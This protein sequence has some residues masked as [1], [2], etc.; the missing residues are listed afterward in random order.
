MVNDFWR[1]IIGSG[2]I[3]MGGGNPMYAQM[4]LQQQR[5]A[6]EK[7][8]A[9]QGLTSAVGQFVPPVNVSPPVQVGGSNAGF[10]YG[11]NATPTIQDI[12]P[13]ILKAAAA[14]VDVTPFVSLLQGM[15]PASPTPQFAPDGR[16]IN[17]SDPKNLGRNFAQPPGPDSLIRGRP[18]DQFFSPTDPTKPVLSIPGA[19]SASPPQ[20]R[21]RVEGDKT[22]VEEFRDGKWAKVSEGPRWAPAKSDDGGPGIT[23]QGVLRREFNTEAG[24]F[25]TVAGSTVRA[26]EAAKD[27]TAA[28]DLALI[29]NYMKI[30]DP[31]SVVRESEFATAQ[32]S[33][34]VPEQIRAQYNRVVNGER[35]SEATRKDFVDRARRLYEGQAG[36]FDKKVLSRYRGLAKQYNIPEENIIQDYRIDLAPYQSLLGGGQPAPAPGPQSAVVPDGAVS[37]LRQNPNLAAQFDAKYGA[38]ASRQYLGR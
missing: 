33:A 8:T 12:S 24:T 10:N 19:P 35:L 27:P 3:G 11:G 37:A 15:Q 25:E 36:Q 23:D 30:L 28:G 13:A 31:G 9:S 17:T 18:G 22:I 26:L 7:K 4:M 5:D 38:G 2:L 34:G 14:G 20:T 1:N 16:L 21:E 6:A 32:N 29:F